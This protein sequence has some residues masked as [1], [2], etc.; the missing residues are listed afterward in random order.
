M[1][2]IKKK[3]IARIILKTARKEFLEKGFKNVSIREIA[4]KAKVS[5]SNIYT[6]FKNKDELFEKILEPLL[7]KIN[8]YFLKMSDPNN[9]GYETY[10]LQ[11]HLDMIIPVADFIEDYREEFNLIFFKSSGSNFQNY[12]NYLIDIYTSISMKNFSFFAKKLNY[13]KTNISKFFVHNIAASYVCFVKEVIMHNVQKEKIVDYGQEFIMYS[14]YG[15]MGLT[16]AD[17]GLVDKN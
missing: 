6:Y 3:E 15:F 16:G 13:T 7:E 1:A 8:F 5:K 2:Q 11:Y 10:T 17:I 4:E 14:Y 12:E 9:F